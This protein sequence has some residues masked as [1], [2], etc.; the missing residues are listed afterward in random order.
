MST[1][2]EIEAAIS[3]L[4]RQDFAALERWWNEYREKLWDAQLAEDSKAG[5]RLAKFLAEVDA[6]IDAGKTTP[7]P[8]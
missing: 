2:H 3:K 8:K 5:G 7:F 6:D 4:P 1:V